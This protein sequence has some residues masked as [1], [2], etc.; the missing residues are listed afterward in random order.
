MNKNKILNIMWIVIGITGLSYVSYRVW[1]TGDAFGSFYWG[2]VFPRLPFV[3]ASILALAAGIGGLA[4]KTW[5]R[6]AMGAVS[7]LALLYSAVI[8][9]LFLLSIPTMNWEYFR[10]IGPL[11]VLPLIVVGVASVIS[12]RRTT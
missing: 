3:I 1:Q 9:I 6:Y 10:L 4:R 5:A 7:A 12:L 8:I 11:I 2:I